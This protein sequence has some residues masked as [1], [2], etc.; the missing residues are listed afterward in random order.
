M[1]F[2]EKEK[3]SVRGILEIFQEQEDGT[4][5]CVI[6]PV[7]N[8]ILDYGRSIFPYLIAGEG[9]YSIGYIYYG[10]GR[11]IGSSGDPE[12]WPANRTLIPTL[13]SPSTAYCPKF[14][15]TSNPDTSLYNIDALEDDIMNKIAM[16]SG[17]TMFEADGL[18]PMPEYMRFRI[19]LHNQSG[20]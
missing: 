9:G 16:Y 5:E 6:G 1:N 15:N 12:D 20:S 10:D 17:G 7:K 3:I 19:R 8:K 14:L 4:F 11:P 18:T 2:S 13:T